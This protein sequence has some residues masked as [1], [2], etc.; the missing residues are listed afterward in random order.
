MSSADTYTHGHHESVLRSHRWRTAENSCAYLLGRLHPGQR[1][2]DV[3]C[4]PGTIT[5]DLATRVA[6]GEVVGID[7]SDE[8]IAQARAA[9]SERAIGNVRFAVGDI[10]ALEVE[11]ASFDVVHAHQVLQHLREPVRA[12]TELR[13]VLRPDGVLAV[14]DSDYGAFAWAPT[15]ERLTR[16]S[17]LYHAITARNGAEADAGRHLLAWVRAAGYNDIEVSSSTWTYADAATRLWWGG[18]WADRVTSSAFAE[19]AVAYGLSSEEELHD[20]AAAWR[21][22]SV[23]DNACIILVHGEVLARP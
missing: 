5:L 6:P 10:Y 16:W 14:R 7:A 20:L 11:A 22:W 15:D 18:L 9:A 3:G 17:E 2:L 13:R 4:G 19:Q 1:L 21:D 12:L 8:V 23:D